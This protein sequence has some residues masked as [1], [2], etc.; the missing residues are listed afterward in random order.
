M[1]IVL[2]GTSGDI[3]ASSLTGVS[4]GKVLQIVQAVKTDTFSTQSNSLVDITGLSLSITPSATSSKIL[5]KVNFNHSVTTVDRWMQFQLMRDSTAIYR[6]DADGS[7][8]RA[9]VFTSLMNT[10]AGSGTHIINSNIEFLDTPNTTSATTY[11]LQGTRQ[12][13]SSPYLVINRPLTTGDY[14][15]NGRPASSITAMEIAA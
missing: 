10:S 7:K 9:S 11:K 13:A 14:S 1:P 12:A 5:V 2:N 15:Y 8:S 6:G 3:S 4:T